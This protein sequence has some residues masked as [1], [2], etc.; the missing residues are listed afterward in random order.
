MFEY[1][2]KKMVPGIPGAPIHEL[3]TIMLVKILPSLIIVEAK[4]MTN[5][6]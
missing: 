5:N 3:L 4:G 6:L 2:Y 1:Y